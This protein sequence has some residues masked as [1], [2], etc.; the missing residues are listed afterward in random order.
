MSSGST[1][2]LTRSDVTE[3]LDYDV[4]I[5]AVEEAF[6]LDG[7][8]RTIPASIMGAHVAG[9]G[10]HV[11]AAGFE[12]TRPYYAVKI[13]ANF[14][15]NRARHGLPTIQ[16]VISLH[17][18]GD[19]RLL[20][21][22]DSIEITTIR[23]AAASAVAATYLAR[24]DSRIVMIIGCG[25]QGRSHLL[26]LSK[27]CAVEKMFAYDTDSSRAHDLA[28][29]MA[30]SFGMTVE[31]VDD[32]HARTHECDIIVTCTPSRE[33]L[34]G[35]SDISPGTFIAAVGADSE[36]KHEIGVDL[37]A[38]STVVADVLDQ[39]ATIGDLHHAIAAGVMRP[40]DVHA[41]LSDLV[42]GMR[43]GRSTREE[44]TIFDSTGTALEDVA[45]ASIVY[46][47]ALSRGGAFEVSLGA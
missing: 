18:A 9:G 31:A 32:Y 43:P 1:L 4:C 40:E 28:S 46:E 8:Q 26:A 20:A 27:V 25:N 23:T 42:C 7:A 13:N 21:L 5:A 45:A 6:R 24:S 44:I 3:L 19:G 14:P 22:L 47:R 10:F 39:C 12:R 33:S 11:K 29:E 35:L 30:A 34:L 38:A 41:E 36:N 2:V 15:D 17:D 16:G 37:L